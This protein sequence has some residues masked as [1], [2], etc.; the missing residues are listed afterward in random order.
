MHDLNRKGAFPIRID[1]I[2]SIA[3]NLG[4]VCD[5]CMLEYVSLR[6]CFIR[7]K[8]STKSFILL[9]VFL[10]LFLVIFLLASSSC[11]RYMNNILGISFL[12][13]NRLLTWNIDQMM[14]KKEEI[15]KKSSSS[16][17]SV[18]VF[19]VIKIYLLYFLLFGVI[20]V[21]FQLERNSFSI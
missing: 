6:L 3:G 15:I 12:Y 13:F 5:R 20:H 10:T 17:F 2:Q 9:S 14:K 11:K 1:K 19:V 16:T 18:V 7:R 8:K 21:F 4:K